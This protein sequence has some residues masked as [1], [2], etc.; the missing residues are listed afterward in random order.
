MAEYITVRGVVGTEIETRL[1][2]GGTQ[3]ANFRLAS[4]ERKLENDQWV[5]KSTNWYRV[6][7]YRYLANNITHS[8]KKGDRVIVTG[9]LRLRQWV[10]DDGHQVTSPEIDAESIGHDLKW[11][12]AKYSRNTSTRT[13]AAQNA[14]P[15]NY[16]EMEPDGNGPALPVTALE[17]GTHMPDEYDRDPGA[18][19]HGVKRSGY[20]AGEAADV[21][22]TEHE[23][24]T[25]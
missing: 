3:T 16:H 13:S 9:K 19:G 8:L 20:E 7:A 22:R 15:D 12:T 21:E 17:Y 10:R 11:G 1:T 14:A 23:T 25:A 6:E 24:M 4:S 18:F 2:N 5:D